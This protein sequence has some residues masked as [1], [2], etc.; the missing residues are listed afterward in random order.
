MLRSTISTKCAT[1]LCFSVVMLACSSPKSKTEA[2]TSALEVGLRLPSTAGLS[3]EIRWTDHGVP[4][5]I[6]DDLDGALFGQ[7]YAN[8]SLNLCTVADIILMANSQRAKYLGEGEKGQWLESDFAHLALGVR[9][10]AEASWAKLSETARRALI[11]YTAGYNHYL[12]QT[13]AAQ[14]P[15]RCRGATWV[16]PI[17][18][19]D[20]L[21]WYLTL[22]LQAGNRNFAQY[23]GTTRP[24]GE[25]WVQLDH[26][27]SQ[28]TWLGR[29]AD[30]ADDWTHRRLFGPPPS[31]SIG[32]NGWGIGG[33]LSANG[34]GMVLANPH[35]PWFGELRFYE[36]HITVRDDPSFGAM[37]VYGGSLLGVPGIQIGF[38]EGFAWTHTVS[39]SSKFTFYRLALKPGDPLTYLVDG[40]ERKITG[41]EVEVEVLQPDGSFSKQTRTY[42][43]SEVGVMAA[44]PVVAEWTKQQAFTIRDANES[45]LAMIDHFLAIDRVQSVSEAQE[46]MHTIQGLPWINL[47][48]ADSAGQA[49]YSD[50]CSEPKLTAAAEAEHAQKIADGDF[51][52][53]FAYDLGAILL[54]GSKASSDWQDDPAARAPGLIPCTEVPQ[55]ERRD[56]VAN[57][58][59]SHWLTNASAPLEG[60]S[61]VFGKERTVRSLRTRMGL[62]LLT[63]PELLTGGANKLDLEALKRAVDGGYALSGHLLREPLVELCEEVTS[64]TVTEDGAAVEVDLSAGCATLKAWDGS[65]RTSSAGAVLFREWFAKYD[66]V[67]ES[68]DLWSKAFDVDSPSTTPDGLSQTDKGKQR[69]LRR[70]ALTIREMKQRGVELD[71]KLG[72]QQ[73][74]MKADERLPVP[75]ATHTEGAFNVI[76][77]SPG[78]DSTTF[79]HFD[80]GKI[81]D[82]TTYRTNQATR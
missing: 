15:Q 74:T 38:T 42:Y 58:N 66:D 57:A 77:W 51:L 40:Q 19:V 23:I 81:I 76:G 36:N 11:A 17:T 37:N 41:T 9:D 4:H 79:G 63:Q 46:V 31:E 53:S 70:L 35:F 72:E 20:L 50:A 6:A 5:V 18:P 29:Y 54:D 62:L 68:M 33:D 69:A 48:C 80:P 64:V 10:R 75:G 65:W 26:G 12:A 45:N 34:K 47:M 3:A 55:L 43:R 49:W 78:R 61:A 25:D 52:T 71:V 59:E 16:K 73:F 21:T 44:L 14:R 32:S 67:N 60:Y 2:D 39:F 82:A 30:F 1:A 7:A 28:A 22:A 24:P 27:S 8:A 56:Y 13:P